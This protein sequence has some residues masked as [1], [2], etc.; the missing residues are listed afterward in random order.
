MLEE[1]SKLNVNVDKDQNSVHL[2]IDN[3]N[4]G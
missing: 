4:H 1:K 3:T 2:Q